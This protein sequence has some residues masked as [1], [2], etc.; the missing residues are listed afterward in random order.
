MDKK[1][2][3]FLDISGIFILIL[4]IFTSTQ[5]LNAEGTKLTSQGIQFPDGTLQTTK[6]VETGTRGY[7]VFDGNGVYIGYLMSGS[8]IFR[9]D[10]PGVFTLGTDTKG[11]PIVQGYGGGMVTMYWKS[12]DCTGTTYVGQGAPFRLYSFDAEYFL[13]NQSGEPTSVAQMQS[14]RYG[15][16]DECVAY[17]AFPGSYEGFVLDLKKIDFPLA[18]TDL[19]YPLTI[20]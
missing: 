6:A 13:L 5:N 1:K 14:V 10:L 7:Q 18:N 8:E 19:V 3:N 11:H 12:A 20:R 16:P 9:P 15:L 4:S 17:V 2:K